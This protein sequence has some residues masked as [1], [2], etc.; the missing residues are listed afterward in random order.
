MADEEEMKEGM[1]RKYW[2][3]AIRVDADV[4]EELQRRSEPFEDKPNDT[5]RRILGMSPRDKGGW[6]SYQRKTK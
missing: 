3:K 1:V 5:L 6:G 2:R 4:Y